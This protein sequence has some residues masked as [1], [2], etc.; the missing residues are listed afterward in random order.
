[1]NDDAGVVPGLD[2]EVR[3]RVVSVEVDTRNIAGMTHEAQ[4]HGF[5]FHSDEPPEMAGNDEHPY[6][7]DYFTAAIGL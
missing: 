6:P 5:T 2:P 7:L 3:R 1:M 4:V